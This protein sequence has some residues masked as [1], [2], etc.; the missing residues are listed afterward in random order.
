MSKFREKL[1]THI[2]ISRSE[3]I[4][5]TFFTKTANRSVGNVAKLKYL[6][7]VLT[8]EICM[9]G[10]TKGGI[11]VRQ[12]LHTQHILR[13]IEKAECLVQPKRV[14]LWISIIKCCV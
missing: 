6:L 13:V 10:E 9:H 1:G 11:R 4:G 2:F 14:A 12:T 7:K 3:D 8:D 5:Q